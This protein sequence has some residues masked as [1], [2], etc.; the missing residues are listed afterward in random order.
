MISDHP[1]SISTLV[2]ISLERLKR[3]LPTGG[4]K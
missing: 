1:F 3:E 4:A 2:I